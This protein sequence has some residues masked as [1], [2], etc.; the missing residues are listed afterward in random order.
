MKNLTVLVDDEVHNLVGGSYEKLWYMF[1]DE[2]KELGVTDYI[3]GEDC[4][5]NDIV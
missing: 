2:A 4:T 1:A 3:I 5:I